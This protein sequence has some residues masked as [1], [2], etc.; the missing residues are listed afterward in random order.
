MVAEDVAMGLAIVLPVS[1]LVA[2]FA[3]RVAASGFLRPPFVRR[4]VWTTLVITFVGDLFLELLLPSL[5]CLPSRH[6]FGLDDDDDDSY[7]Y[8]TTS[9]DF[10]YFP[11]LQQAWG[12]GCP[13]WTTS[14]FGGAGGGGSSYNIRNE[15]FSFDLSHFLLTSEAVGTL[16]TLRLIFMCW[17]VY[18]GETFCPVALTGG[19]ACGKSTVDRLLVFGA[20]GGGNDSGGG[21]GSH[22][23]SSSFSGGGT[24]GGGSHHGK[25]KRWTL[26]GGGTSGSRKSAKHAKRPKSAALYLSEEG[27]SNHSQNH[28]GSSP[29]AWGGSSSLFDDEG[30]FL[31]VDTDSIAHQILLPRSVLES[32]QMGWGGNGSSSYLWLDHY[33][34]DGF[35]DG[36]EFG[37]SDDESDGIQ[38]D[39]GGR[40]AFKS[41]G[42]TAASSPSSGSANAS[43]SL[44]SAAVPTAASS[45]SSPVHGG[46]RK[47]RS[48]RR[49]RF[50][51]TP[52]DSVYDRI[53]AAFGDESDNCR[54]ILSADSLIDRDKLGALVFRD[55]DLRRRLNG[56][57]HPRIF[58]T[59]MKQLLHG[60]YF[61][62]RD[63]VCAD[64]PLLF[65]TMAGLRHMFALVIVVACSREVQFRR[66]RE[67]NP[68]LTPE[69]CWERIDSQMRIDD[70]VARA[71]L[72]IMND[73]TMEELEQ[74]VERVRK[75]VVGRIYG[76]GMSLLQML[77]LVGGSLSLAVSSK[78]FASFSE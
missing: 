25:S 62:S 71:D 52:A 69:Q 46:G 20:G 22:H 14:H 21:G 19:I 35:D 38:Q 57:T 73:G 43:S 34:T 31:I 54:N 58:V 8:Y 39:G 29:S 48:P 47:R 53:L 30:S 15:S 68:E 59:M 49:T 42:A 17:G 60:A 56:I 78:L 6:P 12:F 18:L 3:R 61:S 10:G 64:I 51:V 9:G 74:E 55:R 63:V 75:E 7:Y 70:K 13:A 36:D 11:W 16:L 50:V 24:G 67:R 4:D 37:Y 27:S 26:G 72:V 23:R 33:D 28:H 44:P 1:V 32:S 66:L 65:E 45:P 2:F 77:L 40:G 76:I 41:S 5:R